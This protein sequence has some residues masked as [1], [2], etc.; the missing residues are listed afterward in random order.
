MKALTM[1]GAEGGSLQRT[2]S[3]PHGG[4]K[5]YLDASGSL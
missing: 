2:S 3:L 1:A 5:G 4:E